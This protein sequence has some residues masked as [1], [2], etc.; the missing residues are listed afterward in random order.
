MAGPRPGRPTI[1]SPHPEQT[2]REALSEAVS[3]LEAFE[4]GALP[5]EHYVIHVLP[6]RTGE[7]SW[8][9][10]Y[11]DYQP[12]MDRLWAALFAAGLGEVTPDAYNLWLAGEHPPLETPDEVA[13]LDREEMLLRLFS[14]RRLERFCDGHWTSALTLGFLLAFA[15]RLLE[16]PEDDEQLPTS[17]PR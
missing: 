13:A 8:I 11:P 3:E 10:G 4:R 6:V 7:K 15:R 5:L 9:A 16:R 1:V 12:A 14:I 2:P 17:P